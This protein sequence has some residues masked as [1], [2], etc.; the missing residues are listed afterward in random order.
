MEAPAG[1]G[2]GG[3]MFRLPGMLDGLLQRHGAMLPRGAED[4]ILLIKRDMEE[5]IAILKG[6]PVDG[7][8]TMS[9]SC[10]TK[11]VR[12]LSYDMED[13]IDEYEHVRSRPPTPRRNRK[14]TRRWRRGSTNSPYWLREQ[15]RQRLW[16]ANKIREFSVRAQEAIGRH[17][18]YKLGSVAPNA[19]GATRADVS[20]SSSWQPAVD[21]SSSS[22]W[23]PAPSWHDDMLIGIDATMDK[24]E[25]WLM[26]IH[27]EEHQKLRVVSVVGPGGVGKTTLANELYLKLGQRFECQAFVRTSQRPDMRKL[28]INMLSQLAPHQTPHDWNVHS[29]ISII[30]SHLQYK[31]CYLILIYCQ[32]F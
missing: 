27:G 22:P 1:C 20:S 11:E 19:S 2:L 25:E 12:E 5:I 15:L 16:M 23:Q 9:V 14:V 6:L 30:R 7:R 17:N 24:L 4:E 21:A 31:R 8:S 18:E 13:F 29:L 28:F 32:H 10:W 26:P 3:A